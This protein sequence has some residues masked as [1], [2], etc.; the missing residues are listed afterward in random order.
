MQRQGTA[1]EDVAFIAG[2]LADF[3]QDYTLVEP[4]KSTST[5]RSQPGSAVRCCLQGWLAEQ[6][7]AVRRLLA[8]LRLRGGGQAVPET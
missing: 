4:P 3:P 6:C 7:D 8:S 1:P 5:G 2:L